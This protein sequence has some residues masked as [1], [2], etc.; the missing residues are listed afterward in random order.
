M[1]TG[2]ILMPHLRMQML[3]KQALNNDVSQTLQSGLTPEL[4]RPAKRVRLGRTVMRAKVNPKPVARNGVGRPGGTDKASASTEQVE[5]SKY[6]SRKRRQSVS[7]EAIL[8]RAARTRCVRSRL[9]RS[10][11]ARV[12]RTDQRAI[13]AEVCNAAGVA[14]PPKPTT[15]THLPTHNT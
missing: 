8:C 9:K 2:Q 5:A 13:N 4:S 3:I 1:R 7:H 14:E 6:R 11:G 15:P 10:R 12:N